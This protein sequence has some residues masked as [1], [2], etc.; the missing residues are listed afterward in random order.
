MLIRR[1]A[2]VDGGHFSLTICT[3]FTTFNHPHQ[4]F[5]VTRPK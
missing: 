3:Y 1:A 5:K 4:G 2:G